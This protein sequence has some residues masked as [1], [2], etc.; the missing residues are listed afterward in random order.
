M[1]RRGVFFGAPGLTPAMQPRIGWSLASHDGPRM[2]DNAYTTSYELAKFEPPAE[3]F[4]DIAI[5]LT[6]RPAVAQA[7][8][9]V[10]IEEGRRLSQVLGCVACHAVKDQDYPNV[11]PKWK[12]LF[13]SERAYLTPEK[14]RDKTTADE[15]YVRESILQPTAKTVAGYELFEY[16]M[17]SYAVVV[18]DSQIEA[19]ILYLKTLK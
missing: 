3:G 17:P 15:S 4:G 6:P 11:G 13:G 1:D 18:T 19:L 12:G 9:P 5:D 2:E 10:T 14:N 7:D 8:G 16:A